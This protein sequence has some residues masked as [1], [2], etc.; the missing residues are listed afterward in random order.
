MNSIQLSI[1]KCFIAVFIH[2]EL[3]LNNVALSCRNYE[4]Y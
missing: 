4:I 2:E 1:E 3:Y